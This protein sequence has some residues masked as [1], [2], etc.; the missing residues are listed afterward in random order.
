[1]CI[2][3]L[4]CPPLPL[5]V[6]LKIAFHEFLFSCLLEQLTKFKIMVCI[7]TFTVARVIQM[8]TKLVK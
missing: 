5:K 4:F 2:N 3:G 8:A 1:M 7:L 6:K